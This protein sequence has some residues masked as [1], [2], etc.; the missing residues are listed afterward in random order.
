M[1]EE[2]WLRNRGQPRYRAAAEPQL[3]G[4][5]ELAMQRASCDTE[6][7]SASDAAIRWLSLFLKFGVR[8]M[9]IRSRRGAIMRWRGNEKLRAMTRF[10]TNCWARWPSN[11]APQVH[12]GKYEEKCQSYADMIESAGA[13]FVRA[14]RFGLN[15][16]VR[17]MATMI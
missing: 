9:N 16:T 15:A 2:E 13:S 4:S 6:Q 10:R 8:Q 7:S 5:G 14:R 12:Q 3:A 1:E 11:E 17:F